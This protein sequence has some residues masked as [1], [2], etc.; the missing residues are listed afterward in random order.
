MHDQLHRA[1][2]DSTALKLQF[3]ISFNHGYVSVHSL[4][5]LNDLN[6]VGRTSPSC[7]VRY[8]QKLCDPSFMVSVL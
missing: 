8:H 2:P 5:L 4:V 7:G 6:R 3:A 1:S